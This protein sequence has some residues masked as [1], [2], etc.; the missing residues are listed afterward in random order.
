MDQWEVLQRD[1]LPAYITWQQFLEN[2]ERLRQNRATF[3]TLGAPRE[4]SALLG[5]LIRCGSCGRRMYVAYSDKP[6]VPRYVCKQQALRLGDCE[7]QNLTGRTIDE[8]VSR[9]VWQVLEPASVALSLQVEEHVVRE[10]QRLE[11]HWRQKLERAR[12][13]TDRAQRQYNAAEPENRLVVRELERRWEQALVDERNCQ[14]EYVRFQR[15]RSA[16]ISAE[17]RERW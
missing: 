6:N 17:E 15:D 12:F 8:L 13:H 10:Q 2:Q 1:V 11:R 3:E 14:E 5:G 7:N 16:P 4:G 9:Q